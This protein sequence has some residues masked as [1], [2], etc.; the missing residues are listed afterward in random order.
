MRPSV[1]LG[2]SRPLL[3]RVATSTNVAGTEP[4]PKQA[5]ERGQLTM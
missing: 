1:S 2:F 4:R 5:V 3:L